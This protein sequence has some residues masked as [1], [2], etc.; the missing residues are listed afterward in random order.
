MGGRAIFLPF[1]LNPMYSAPAACSCTSAPSKLGSVLMS[2]IEW[3]SLVALIKENG[4]I[5]S[6]C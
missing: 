4:K 1:G 3:R 2:L 6:P 5:F